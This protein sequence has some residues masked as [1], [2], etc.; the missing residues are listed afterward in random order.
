M[1]KSLILKFTRWL[2]STITD[3][4]LSKTILED[5]EY[6][7]EENCKTNKIFAASFLHFF[8]LIIIITPLLLDNFVEYWTHPKAPSNIDEVH[9]GFWGNKLFFYKAGK[10]EKTGVLALGLA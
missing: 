1:F 2:I 6:R 9:Y 7:F 5:L 8:H 10:T 3:M 4:E